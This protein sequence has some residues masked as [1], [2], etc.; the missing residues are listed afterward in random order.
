MNLI[1]LTKGLFFLGTSHRLSEIANFSQVKRLN[2]LLY[3]IKPLLPCW[4]PQ[5]L[6]LCWAV[7]DLLPWHAPFLGPENSCYSKIRWFTK[8]FSLWYRKAKPSNILWIFLVAKAKIQLKPWSILINPKSSLSIILSPFYQKE[9]WFFSWTNM[10]LCWR[11]LKLWCGNLLTKCIHLR[12][13]LF[14]LQHLFPTVFPFPCFLL[15]LRIVYTWGKRWSTATRN[16]PW[17]CCA[18]V[19]SPGPG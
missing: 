18:L 19:T 3:S 15:F 4:S 8:V 1:L 7:N 5:I 16:G 9:V 13:H 11:C 17:C 10:F 14:L 12:C 6:P 2:L